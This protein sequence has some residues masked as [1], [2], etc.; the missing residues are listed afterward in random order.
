M[1]IEDNNIQSNEDL[2]HEVPGEQLKLSPSQ[3]RA[4]AQ[5]WKPKDQWE[6]EDDEFIDAAEFVRRGELFN[7]IDSQ[8]K[9]L[10]DVKRALNEL[11]KMH[12]KVSEVEYKRALDS[13]KA[14]KKQALLEG[15]ADAVIDID[16]R[17]DLVKEQ[18]KI[19]NTPQ[20][21]ENYTDPTE[22]SSW[23]SKNAWYGQD[24]GLTK[25]ADA[26]GVALAREGHSP[27]DVLRLVEREVK[28]EFKEKF[29][30]PNRTRAGA[31]EGSGARPGGG[32]GSADSYELT[33]QERQVM[34]TLVRQGVLTKEQYIKDLKAVKGQD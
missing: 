16:D 11:G 12:A 8:S 2:G 19:Q 14:Q 23:K 21:Q 22:F 7:K 17:I 32:K 33:P 28:E 31:V 20:V 13:L 10:K 15:D 34:N 3:E 18:S 25:Y 26:R 29:S 6:G 4:L 30:N 1:A 24:K 27:S 9:E 5:G